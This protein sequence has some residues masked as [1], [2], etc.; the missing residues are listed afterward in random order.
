VVSAVVM[1]SDDVPAAWTSHSY[2]FVLFVVFS[3]IPCWIEYFLWQL[4]HLPVSRKLQ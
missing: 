4:S 1:L 3:T 2:F